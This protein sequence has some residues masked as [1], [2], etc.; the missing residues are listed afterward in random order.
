MRTTWSR[1]ILSATLR[2]RRERIDAGGSEGAEGSEAGRA[3]RRRTP[4]LAPPRAD[5]I[6]ERVR[7][8]TRTR[9]P[10]SA[11]LADKPE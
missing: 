9:W 6:Q 10:R 7:A 5:S 11:T 2:L 4:V 3:A 1:A 8:R